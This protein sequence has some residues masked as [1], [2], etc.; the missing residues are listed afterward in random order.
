LIELN[1]ASV[2]LENAPDNLQAE[3][4]AGGASAAR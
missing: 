2:Q 4:R 3:T 1:A